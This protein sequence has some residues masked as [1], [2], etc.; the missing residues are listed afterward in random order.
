MPW[1]VRRITAQSLLGP[2]AWS[3]YVDEWVSRRTRARNATSA[4]AALAVGFDAQEMARR[5]DLV[6]AMPVAFQ[7]HVL[8]LRL[9]EMSQDSTRTVN[10]ADLP[11]G[12]MHELDTGDF[13]LCAV[14]D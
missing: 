2:P 11:D 1:E 6:A 9:K 5:Y 10:V 14:I 3:P 8:F 7:Q 12:N 4:H 13:N